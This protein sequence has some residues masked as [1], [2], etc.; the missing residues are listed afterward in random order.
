MCHSWLCPLEIDTLTC[1]AVSTFISGVESGINIWSSNIWV[2]SPWA[3][4]SGFVMSMY[5][6]QVPVTIQVLCLSSLVWQLERLFDS[7]KTWRHALINNTGQV[8]CCIRHGGS[9]YFWPN[10]YCTL[11]WVESKMV[12]TWRILGIVVKWR[13][14]FSLGGGGI[15]GWNCLSLELQ[16][17]FEAYPV[18]IKWMESDSF[19]Q[20]VSQ[21]VSH[22]DFS[23]SVLALL[24][25][26]SRKM[27]LITFWMLVYSS[28]CMH[29]HEYALSLHEA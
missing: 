9:R 27:W 4:L 14:I 11:H 16:K 15:F 5:Y 23:Q 3:S 22:S 7:V 25:V 6:L 1:I 29:M 18:F 26:S 24:H 21:S 28:S 2:C 20:Y 17:S 13:W 12:L 19:N 10:L 8:S